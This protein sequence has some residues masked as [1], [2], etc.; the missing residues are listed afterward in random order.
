[1]TTLFLFSLTRQE[2]LRRSGRRN[3]TTTTRGSTASSATNSAPSST[4]ASRTRRGPSCG[5]T[6]RRSTES[7]HPSPVYTPN[8]KQ[9]TSVAPG[10][11]LKHQHHNNRTA[12]PSGVESARV[13]CLCCFKKKGREN[14]CLLCWSLRGFVLKLHSSA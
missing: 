5:S 14:R 11:S 3:T 7:A 8:T 9:R 10:L 1:M 4:N 2:R 12:R 6:R 13:C